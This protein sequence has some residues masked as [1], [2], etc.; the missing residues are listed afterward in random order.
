MPVI[1]EI[2]KIVELPQILFMDEIVE[3]PVVMDGKCVRQTLK[4]TWMLPQNLY[5]DK[6]F[7]VPVAMQHQVPQI[8]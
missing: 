6:I 5:T 4:N 8:Q 2:Q 3:M 7:G 1:Q